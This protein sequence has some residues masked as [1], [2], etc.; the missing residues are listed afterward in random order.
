MTKTLTAVAREASKAKGASSRGGEQ[1]D[2]GIPMHTTAIHIPVKTWELLR[3]LAFYRAKK[4]GGR[5]SVSKAIA[6][7]VEQYREKIEHEIN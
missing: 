3:D 4:T 2:S 1:Y 6:D 5:A 7:V